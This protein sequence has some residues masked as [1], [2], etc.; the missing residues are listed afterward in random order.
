MNIRVLLVAHGSGAYGANQSLINIVSALKARGVFVLIILPSNGEIC[1]KFDAYGFNYKIINYSSEL[2]DNSNTLFLKIYN[3]LRN[4]KKNIINLIALYELKKIVITNNINIIHSNSAVVKIGFNLAVKN[5]IHHIWHLREY[6]HPNYDLHVFGGF[7]K[8][9]KNI[10]KSY[11]IIS[12]STGVAKRFDVFNKCII[13]RDAVRKNPKYN[14]P[15]SKDK[16]FLFCGSLH[17]NKGIEEAIDAFKR[18]FDVNCEYKL[19]VVGT[20][21]LEYE[22]YLKNKVKNLNMNSHVLFFGFRN[23]IDDLMFKA[24]AFLMC[25]RN[26]ALGRVTIEA[27]LNFCLVFGYNDSGTSEIIEDSKT[28]FLYN[29]IDE[30]VVLM[31]KSIQN[32]SFFDEVVNNAYVHAKSNYLED[33]FGDNLMDFYSKITLNNK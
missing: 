4:L 22:I 2:C 27:M 29:S 32:L 15:L 9:K 18:V 26:E 28:G 24:T 23:D 13:L 20:G 12:I 30:L 19:I 11:K 8:Y 7:E 21:D 16:Y 33:K 3:L 31:F 17:K 5:K 1:E 10:Q 25:S 6:I 14:I